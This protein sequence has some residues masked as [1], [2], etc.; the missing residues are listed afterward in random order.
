MIEI[1]PPD[2][3]RRGL[4]DLLEH[5]SAQ[6]TS[7]R[8]VRPTKSSGCLFAEAWNDVI[9]AMRNSD[10]INDYE[11]EVLADRFPGFSKPVYLP[12][13]VTAGALERASAAANDAAAGVSTLTT[14]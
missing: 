13:F 5:G 8:S 2:T 6:N 7:N 12:I 11:R 10:V 4:L 9:S 3:A 14:F 1:P